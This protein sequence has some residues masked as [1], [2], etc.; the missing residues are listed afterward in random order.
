MRV[1]WLAKPLAPKHS[2]ETHQAR[3]P[4]TVDYDLT[5]SQA[6]RNPDGGWW[7]PQFVGNSESPF[8]TINAHEGD[9]IRVHIHNDASLI[10]TQHWVGVNHHSATWNDGS[11]GVTTYPILPRSN[12]TSTFNT[13]G[14]WGLKWYLEHASTASLDGSHG[15]VWIRPSPERER[16]YHLVSKDPL[17]VQD[18]LDAEEKPAHA[19]VHGWQHREIPTLLAQLQ[20]EGYD[21]YCYQS[22]L[23]NGKARVHCKPPGLSTLNGNPVDSHGCVVQATGAVAYPECKP[24]EGEYEVFETENR[25]WMLFNFV[26]A[27]LEHSWHISIDGHKM[28]I[29]A[30]DGGY[31]QPQEVDVVYLNNAER[32]TVMVKLDQAAQDYAIRWYSVSPMQSL[33]SYAILRYPHRQV[34]RKLGEVIPQPEQSTSKM[35]FDGTLK[36]GFVLEDKQ[37]EHPYPAQPP[38]NKA[39]ITLRFTAT[40]APD[41]KNPFVTNCSLNG[42]V[43]QIWRNFMHPPAF[44]PKM[45]LPEDYPVERNLPLG[46]TVDVIVEN[47]LPVPLPMYKHNKATFF[48]GAGEGKF[49]YL[50]VATASAQDPSAFNLEDP[51]LGYIHEL[52]AGG[53]LAVRWKIED[54]AATM[55]HAFKARYFV[56]GMQVALLEGDDAWPEVPDEVRN[57]DHVDFNEI[58]NGGIFD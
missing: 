29:V 41:K 27:G 16:P 26:N 52:P 46:S 39:D 47:D 51:P 45:D 35:E 55:F 38:P 37:K 22:A 32:T 9:T 17:D 13:T 43:W 48:L 50:D 30:N 8:A 11:A 23:I 5:L 28:W 40:G 33:Q 42:K 18:M 53:W 19:L 3:V 36:K 54:A 56:L 24:S 4:A 58:K 20:A 1:R 21:P 49:G 31:V 57:R 7:R 44:D 25:R 12:F 34:G 15:T 6:W 2:E 14:Q 10:S